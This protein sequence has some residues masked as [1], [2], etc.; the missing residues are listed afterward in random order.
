MVNERKGKQ[1]KEG[2]EKPVELDFGLGNL[3]LGG[4]FKGLGNFVEL[5]NKL[6]EQGEELKGGKEFTFKTPGGKEGRGVFGFSVRTLAGGEPVV[7][8]FGNIKKTPKGPVVE[9]VREPL[10]DVFDEQGEIRVIAEMPGVSEEDIAVDLNG[11]ILTLKAEGK[12]H[13]YAKEILL[14]SKINAE[15]LQKSFRNGILEIKVRKA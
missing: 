9:E 7:K 3:S 5:A 12:G 8:T 2:E 11:D 4:L 6:A 1:P 15:S 10:V 13:K 14:S